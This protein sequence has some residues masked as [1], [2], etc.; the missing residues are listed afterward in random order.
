MCTSGFCFVDCPSGMTPCSL[1]CVNLRTDPLHC[2][3]C[4]RT[5]PEG[6]VCTDG[7]CVGGMCPRG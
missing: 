5:C 1:R 2:G 7:A 6:A 3:A 4:G